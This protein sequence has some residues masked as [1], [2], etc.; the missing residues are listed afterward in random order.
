MGKKS[1]KK[2]TGNTAASLSSA[3]SASGAAVLS[4]AV[5]EGRGG[6]AD[7]M[8]LLAGTK[9]A[10]P[11]SCCHGSNLADF[12]NL[13]YK[14]AMQAYILMLSDVAKLGMEQAVGLQLLEKFNDDHEHLTKHDANFCQF[15]FAYCTHFYQ[16]YYHLSATYKLGLTSLLRLG[17]QMRYKDQV[18]NGVSIGPG[19]ENCDKW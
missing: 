7:T 9:L 4:S 12:K 13:E 1:R 14:G 15:V 18:D 17:L 5:G 11:S 2:K 8:T 16:K 3:A 6:Y 10:L 19:S